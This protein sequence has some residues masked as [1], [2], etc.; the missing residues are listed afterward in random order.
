MKPSAKGS[1]L[2]G[3]IN[4]YIG[5]GGSRHPRFVI[6]ISLLLAKCGPFLCTYGSTGDSLKL[7]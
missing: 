6:G 2:L 5:V 3:C 1:L 7:K 4:V